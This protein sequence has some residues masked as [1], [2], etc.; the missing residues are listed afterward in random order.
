MNIER[1][2]QAIGIGPDNMHATP[3][4][5]ND[6]ISDRRFMDQLK[7]VHAF[8]RFLFEE[9]V[10]FEPNV[11]ASIDLG[12]LNNLNFRVY[13]RAPTLDEWKQLDEKLL[14]LTSLLTEDLRSRIR[15]RELGIFFGPIPIIFLCV[16][17]GAI[18]WFSLFSKIF[19][20]TS[21][22]AY[23]V[24][25]WASVIL[26]S[27]A[28]GGLGA[29]AFLGT[30]I[31]VKRAEGASISQT[32]EETADVTDRNVLK[33]RILLGCL[34]GFLLGLPFSAESLN[35]MGDLVKSIANFDA[36][37]FLY[38]VLPFMIGFSTNLVLAILDRLVMSVRTFFGIA[39]NK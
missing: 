14:A 15:I 38:V 32:L 19:T 23:S 34:F 11:L 33:I 29:C 3:K 7:E 12:S 10:K 30:R 2:G 24:N 6:G 1:L 16:A 27:L 26:W 22:V 4:S 18:F 25:F 35:Q 13:G 21:S 36:T 20:D 31:A 5:K 39:T 17:I 9:K 8:K 28:Q 37:K